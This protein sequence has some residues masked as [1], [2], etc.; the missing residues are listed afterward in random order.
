MEA[1]ES[2][3]VLEHI[4]MR[5]K[6]LD[7]D[8]YVLHVQVGRAGQDISWTPKP[9]TCMHCSLI[10]QDSNLPASDK[11]LDGDNYVLHVQVS[12]VETWSTQSHAALLVIIYSSVR[13]VMA[14]Q[15]RGRQQLAACTCA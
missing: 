10:Q 8:N 3:R 4:L 13:A 5:N 11:V 12:R 14:E 9:A 6:V 1:V 15:V 2:N 7:G